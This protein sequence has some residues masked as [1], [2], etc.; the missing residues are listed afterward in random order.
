M[1]YNIHEQLTNNG[2]SQSQKNNDTK[3]FIY[4]KTKPYDEF[5]INYISTKKMEITVPIPFNYDSILYKCTF[6]I[7]DVDEI[8]EFITTHLNNYKYHNNL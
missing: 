7:Q 8:N 1:L 2:W 5:V 6:N 4:V 3:K